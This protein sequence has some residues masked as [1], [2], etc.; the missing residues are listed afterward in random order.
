MINYASVDLVVEEI[1][2]DHSNVDNIYEVMLVNKGSS[3]VQ[4]FQYV[5]KQLQISITEANDLI[6]SAPC[7]IKTGL[8]RE[9]AEKIEKEFKEWGALAVV[10]TVIEK[11]EVINAPMHG[12]CYTV[13]GDYLSSMFRQLKLAAHSSGKSSE[14]KK[15][16][17]GAFIQKDSILCRMRLNSNDSQS[18]EIRSGVAGEVVAVLIDN[19]GRVVPKQPLFVVK[20]T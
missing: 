5:A 11:I 6:N 2:E 7:V 4:L 20:Y 10:K 15:I 12:V 17:V 19:G 3:K 8:S 16:S 1:V 14:I 18:R 13:E 9:E